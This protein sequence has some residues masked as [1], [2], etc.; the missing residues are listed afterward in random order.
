[1]FSTIIA[2]SLGAILN[3]AMLVGVLYYAI[4]GAA[5]TRVDTLV[6]TAF[7]VTFL[8]LG[9]AFLYIGRLVTGIPILHPEDH[10][11]RGAIASGHEVLVTRKLG[12]LV[13]ITGL[14]TLEPSS[15]VA[16][17]EVTGPFQVSLLNAALNKPEYHGDDWNTPTIR[18]PKEKRPVSSK[19][20]E[21][22][23][24]DGNNPTTHTQR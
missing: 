6:A 4:V 1:V 13:N 15:E 21:Y 3:V 22:Q 20:T 16:E 7:S 9:F 10:K 14:L 8:V 11:T 17:T 2:P 5:N 18:V 12:P 24:K 23:D 19:E